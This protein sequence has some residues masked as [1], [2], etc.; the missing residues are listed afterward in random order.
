MSESKMMTMMTSM[1]KTHLA[2]NN[3]KC[4]NPDPPSTIFKLD[5]MVEQH[6]DGS[7]DDYEKKSD[8]D[9]VHVMKVDDDNGSLI[10]ISKNIFKKEYQ[11]VSTSVARVLKQMIKYDIAAFFNIFHRI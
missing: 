6:P 9:R 8:G 11:S 5:R 10:A 1:K 7:E 4:V 3:G 2:M